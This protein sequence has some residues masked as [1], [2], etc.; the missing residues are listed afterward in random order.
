MPRRVAGPV[1][2]VI[3]GAPLN[4]VKGPITRGEIML[5]PPPCWLYLV[6]VFTH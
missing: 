5:Q 1:S 3:V 2:P 6:I 4:S